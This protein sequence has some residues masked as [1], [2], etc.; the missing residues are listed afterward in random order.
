MRTVYEGSL[1][2]FDATCELLDDVASKNL[3]PKI[4]NSGV[5]AFFELS[6]PRL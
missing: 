3:K 2:I 5:L 6:R 1:L 4:V